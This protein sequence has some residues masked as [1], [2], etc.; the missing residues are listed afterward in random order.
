[1][2]RIIREVIPVDLPNDA[3]LNELLTVVEAVYPKLM[4]PRG[5]EDALDSNLQQFRRAL[6]YLC[7]ARRSEDLA[8]GHA[9]VFWV[10]QCREWCRRFG[11][12]DALEMSL[13]PFV[14]AIIAADVPFAPLTRFPYDL[15][16]GL[17]LGDVRRPND[18]WRGV[19]LTGQVPEPTKP[20]RVIPN[21][22]QE[23]NFPRPS[24][25]RIDRG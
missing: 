4:C 2:F 20:R 9:A 3:E 6:T 16:F 8:T 23:L 18:A 19:L 10:D 17:S 24:V 21:Y 5:G 7:Y 22:R 25:T 14:A 15:A 11:F 1:M 13:R 12:R